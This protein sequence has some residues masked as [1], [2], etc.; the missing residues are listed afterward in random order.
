[1]SSDSDKAKKLLAAFVSHN[2]SL[3][4]LINA[5]N[6]NPKVK[7]EMN[8]IAKKLQSA[9][10]QALANTPVTVTAGVFPDLSKLLLA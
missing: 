3:D 9:A 5:L 6:A 8:K 10:E 7:D 4:T 2:I 1:M